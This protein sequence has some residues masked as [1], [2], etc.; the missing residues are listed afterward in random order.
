MEGDSKTNDSWVMMD[1][2]VVSEG[3][4]QKQPPMV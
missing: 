3:V 4:M 2:V 1:E